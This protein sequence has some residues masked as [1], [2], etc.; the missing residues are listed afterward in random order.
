MRII[1]SSRS[2]STHTG[3]STSN[4]SFKKEKRY[5]DCSLMKALNFNSGN[6]Y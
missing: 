5:R 3:K 2:D 4:F 6:T 1:K